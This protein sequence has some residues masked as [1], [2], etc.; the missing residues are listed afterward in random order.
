MFEKDA[1]LFHHLSVGTLI[2]AI[3]REDAHQGNDNASVHALK[4][5]VWVVTF[6]VEESDQS[7]AQLRSQIWS[8]S[9]CKGPPSLWVTINPCDLHD[10]I[11]QASRNEEYI[12]L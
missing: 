11:V 9:I 2:Q 5:H 12:W 10:P 1:H 8:T 7:R 4:K 6:C 3:K